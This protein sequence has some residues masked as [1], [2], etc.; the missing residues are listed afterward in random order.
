MRNVAPQR[1]VFEDLRCCLLPGESRRRVVRHGEHD[2]R[3]YRRR[4]SRL[5]MVCGLDPQHVLR[6]RGHVQLS[7]HGNDPQVRIDGKNVAEIPRNDRVGHPGVVPFVVVYRKSSKYRAPH[8]RRFVHFP[9]KDLFGEV[10]DVVVV[11]VHDD[12]HARV[13]SLGWGTT[14]AD[15]D[16][17]DV[18]VESLPV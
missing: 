2:V 16:R 10:G 8:H 12:A 4:Q 6:H 13:V 9:Y 5:S 7:S 14:I 17:E 3:G 1:L 15:H 18:L 11:V